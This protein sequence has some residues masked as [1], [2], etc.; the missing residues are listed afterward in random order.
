MK[1]VTEVR[2]RLADKMNQQAGLVRQLDHSL[3]IQAFEPR[4]FDD[5][6]KCSIGGSSNAHRPW[7]GSVVITL[8]DG[9]VKTHKALD[10]PFRLWPEPMQA[11]LHAIAADKRPKQLRGL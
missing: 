6:G 11:E 3:A 4:A 5:P 1:T 7:E 9:T 2:A 10:V 8:A